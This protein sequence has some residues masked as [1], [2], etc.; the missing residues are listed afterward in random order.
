MATWSDVDRLA[1]RLPDAVLGAAHE[2]SP[3]WY[4]GR[5]AFAR[6]RMDEDA[7]E[8]VQLW[9]GDMDTELVLRDRPE[10]FPWAWTFTYRVSFV[11]VLERMDLG[12]LA[13]LVLDSYAIRGGVKRAAAV[14][15]AAYFAGR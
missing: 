2:G 1:G 14:D 4:A 13:E 7:R 15:R 8:L 6:F 10:V 11:G 9:S 3:A 5:H 12:E